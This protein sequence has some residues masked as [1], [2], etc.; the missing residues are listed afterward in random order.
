VDS[1]RPADLLDVG[2][3]G[4]VGLLVVGRGSVAA[5]ADQ[6]VGLTDSDGRAPSQVVPEH[7]TGVAAGLLLLFGY[8]G[9]RGYQ[10]LSRP[11]LRS[12]PL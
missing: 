12:A 1:P 5:V 11:P 6:D 3:Q 8:R 7:K 10:R 9:A 2:S 4:T